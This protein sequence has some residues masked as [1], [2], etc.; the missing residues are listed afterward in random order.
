MLA[1]PDC[2]FKKNLLVLN[3]DIYVYERDVFMKFNLENFLELDTTQ[4]L[5]V[6][7]GSGCGGSSGGGSSSGGSSGSSSSSSGSSSGGGSSSYGGGSSGSSSGGGGGGSCGGV[8]SSGMSSNGGG[9]SS[10]GGGGG[11]CG[12]STKTT[13]SIGSGVKTGAG[14]GGGSC[15]GI[16]AT[17]PSYDG[18]FS[19][20]NSD[21]THG[22]MG[23]PKPDSV[24]RTNQPYV[25]SAMER[26]G[27]HLLSK[28]N[29]RGYTAGSERGY[30][31]GEL[32]DAY[33]NPDYVVT[34]DYSTIVG[35]PSAGFGHH[36][37][38]TYIIS[39]KNTGTVLFELADVNHDGYMDYAK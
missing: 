32:N 24:D 23:K 20:N 17:A 15:S 34:K 10:G 25:I 5:A 35:S 8:S 11:S 3:C 33:S 37:Y 27:Y 39:D 19:E 21:S 31:Q 2:I 12:G 4:L 7:G 29:E 26:Q 6:N 18:N 30:Y 16:S 22:G 14:G 1:S 13:V 38:D 36:D 28:N 9:A